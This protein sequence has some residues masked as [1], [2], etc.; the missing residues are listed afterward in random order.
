MVTGI[1]T[2][3][4]EPMFSSGFLG[5]TLTSQLVS[6]WPRQKSKGISYHLH[7]NKCII[8]PFPSSSFSIG[9]KNKDFSQPQGKRSVR[10]HHIYTHLFQGKDVLVEVKLD[11]L[12]GDVDAQLL[13]RVLLE[14]L[15]AEDVQ[16][17]HIHAALRST[18]KPSTEGRGGRGVGVEWGGGGDKQTYSSARWKKANPPSSRI[19]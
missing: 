7:A 17:S 3:R 19:D 13:K 14:V 2:S 4:P 10:S 12:I 1:S 8:H 5:F 16:D 6:G 9:D 18:S 11:L 15:E